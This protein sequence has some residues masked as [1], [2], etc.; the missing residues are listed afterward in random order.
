MNGLTAQARSALSMS[1]S[2]RN[3][4]MSPGR[5]QRNS[6]TVTPSGA[7]HLA[8]R[9]SDSS[10]DVRPASRRR[11]LASSATSVI[12]FEDLD[13]DVHRSRPASKS[14][15]PVRLRLPIQNRHS[16]FPP[17]SY[18]TSA[19]LGC[20]LS[21]RSFAGIARTMVSRS[22]RIERCLAGATMRP[23]WW[24]TVSRP[25]IVSKARTRPRGDVS[26]SA[27]PSPPSVSTRPRRATRSSE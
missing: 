24:S 21:E 1:A 6:L 2:G 5:R 3:R 10:A 14:V 18:R 20:Q 9:I 27:S 15:D 12:G 25:R 4:R 17:R 11:S 13:F 23:S 26:Y 19:I 16:D 22:G 8:A 7:L